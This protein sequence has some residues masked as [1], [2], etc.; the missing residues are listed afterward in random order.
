MLFLYPIFLATSVAPIHRT[1]W[2][3]PT[4][5]T[6]THSS[7]CFNL[8]FTIRIRPCQILHTLVLFPLLF[9]PRDRSLSTILERWR[10][11]LLGRLRMAGS[12]RRD[13][14]SFQEQGDFESAFIDFTRAAMIVLQR[15]P[16]HPDYRDLTL[17]QRN[18]MGLVS[19]LHLLALPHFAC[20]YAT[21]CLHMPTN[22]IF[23]L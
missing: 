21:G 13:A 4:V 19:C 10:T 16:S 23:Y 22:S 12:A 1:P 20:Y 7:V 3:P 17:T 2:I 9:K 15:I 6:P 14:K 11:S 18:A 8:R 5:P